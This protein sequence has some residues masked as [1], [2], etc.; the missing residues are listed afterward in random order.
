MCDS[1]NLPLY[2]FCLYDNPGACGKVCGHDINLRRAYPDDMDGSPRGLD[3]H[4]GNICQM[5]YGQ[6]KD[7]WYGMV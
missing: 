3:V 6:F 2:V 5:S 7:I 1:L 4:T